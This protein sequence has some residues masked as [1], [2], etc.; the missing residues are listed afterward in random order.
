MYP[1]ILVPLDG[2]RL[3]ERVLPYVRLMASGG[4]CTV[5]LVRVIPPLA[6]DLADFFDAIIPDSLAAGLRNQAGDYL[7]GIAA[8]LT[9]EGLAVSL[10]VG[11][12]EPA[13]FIVEQAAQDPATLIAMSTHGW[14][15]DPRWNLGSVTLKVL[16]ASGNPV[17]VVP[18]LDQNG[19]SLEARLDAIIAPVDG[20]AVSEQALDQIAS[21]ASSRHLKIVLT[22]VTPASWDYYRFLDHTVLHYGDLSTDLTGRATEYLRAVSQRLRE[23]GV[24]KV[25]QRILHG[26]PAEAIL[27]L[28][29]EIPHSL[30][31]MATHGQGCSDR[32]RWTVGSVTQRVA[33][34]TPAPLLAV[35]VRGHCAG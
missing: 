2:S 7:E 20:S 31:T 32:Y 9:K 23:Q 26:D 16:Q 28:A 18:A 25:E 33:G 12:G 8:D 3:A 29:R 6:S 1:R 19:A 14:S 11:P 21:L 34:S 30:I 17:L 4:A 13:S 35:P 5:E 22:R 15:G 27:D 24:E 10:A